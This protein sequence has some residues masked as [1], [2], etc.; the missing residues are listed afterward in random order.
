MS[1]IKKQD[2]NNKSYVK[3]FLVDLYTFK[4]LKIEVN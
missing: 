4:H 1:F 3:R 2:M